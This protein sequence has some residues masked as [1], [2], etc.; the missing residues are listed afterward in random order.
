[1][2]DGRFDRARFTARLATRRLGRALVVRGRTGSSNDD[3]WE[4]LAA[5]QP[6]GVAVVAGE[7]TAGRGRAGRTWTHVPGRSLAMSVALHLGC[8][9]RQ[10]GVIPLAAGLAVARASRALGV[11]ARLKWPND[12]LARGRKL[13]GVLCELR[14]LPDGTEAVVIGIGVN[15]AHAPG[16]FGPGLRG[17]ATSLA[18]EGAAGVTPEDAAASCLNQLEPLWDELQ[19]GD[20]SRVLEAWTAHAAFWGERVTVRTPAGP[21]EGIARRLEDDG[22]LVLRLDS[23]AETIVRAGDLEPTGAERT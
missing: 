4:A 10:A 16:D 17:S 11:E 19:E 2:A 7:Q 3:A 14:R 12:V 5:G 6:D 21:L 8:D 22:A 18:I 13:A 15:V 23:G 9:V 1:M 20:R